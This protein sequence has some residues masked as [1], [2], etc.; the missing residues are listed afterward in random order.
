MVWRSDKLGS[1]L[2]CMSCGSRPSHFISLNSNLLIYEMKM[3][4]LPLEGGC[5]VSE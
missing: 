2:A 4:P 5:R 1:I 3:A